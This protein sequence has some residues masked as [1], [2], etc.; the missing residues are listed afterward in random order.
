MPR[1]YFEQ[2]SG[3]GIIEDE[4]GSDLADAAL[5]RTYALKA[6][7]E[8]LAGCI[9][10]DRGSPPDSIVVRDIGGAHIATVFVDAVLPESIRSRLR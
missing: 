4:E 2:R 8:I 10:F 3:A 6:M 7:R 1:Y 9:R 5:A